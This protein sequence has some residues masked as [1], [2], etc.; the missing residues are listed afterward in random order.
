VAAALEVTFLPIW[1]PSRPW[2]PVACTGRS[3]PADRPLDDADELAG[4]VV[5]GLLEAFLGLVP[6]AAM[7][8]SW[9]SSEIVSSRMS[10]TFG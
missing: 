2:G 5:Q 4:E 7:I 9:Y 1:R 6:A 8:V 10:S 3:D